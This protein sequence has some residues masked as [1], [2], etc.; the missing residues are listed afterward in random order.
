MAS[1]TAPSSL[2]VLRDQYKTR[3]IHQVRLLSFPSLLF[4]IFHKL[5]STSATITT[6]NMV[7]WITVII[8]AIASLFTSTSAAPLEQIVRALAATNNSVA[9]RT[10]VSISLAPGGNPSAELTEEHPA[11]YALHPDPSEARQRRLLLRVLAGP[12]G[13]RCQ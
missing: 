5:Q 13:H 2:F 12:R 8:W 1:H 3:R 6:C 10:I 11:L 4:Y 7:V 9:T